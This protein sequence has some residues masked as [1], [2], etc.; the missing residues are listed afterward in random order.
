MTVRFK[1]NL[2]D[3]RGLNKATLPKVGSM[4]IRVNKNIS[5]AMSNERSTEYIAFI[6]IAVEESVRKNSN[7]GDCRELVALKK[8]VM[9]P[10]TWIEILHTAEDPQRTFCL[11]IN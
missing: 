4:T 10:K 2:E 8:V 6:A 5:V 7:C 1:Q 9:K 3:G 11:N